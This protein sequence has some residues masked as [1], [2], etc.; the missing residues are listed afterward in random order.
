[1][2]LKYHVTNGTNGLIA[3]APRIESV[4]N[5]NPKSQVVLSLELKFRVGNLKELRFRQRQNHMQ[6][7]MEE[8]LYGFYIM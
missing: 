4:L 8:L 1:M 6:Q 5:S 3:P 2:L 7:F